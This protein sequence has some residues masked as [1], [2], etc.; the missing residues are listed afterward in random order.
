MAEYYLQSPVEVLEYQVYWD[1]VI[2]DGVTIQTSVWVAPTPLVVSSESIDAMFTV[3]K[4]E[5]G[6][7]GKRYQVTNTITRSN[8]EI[9]SSSLFIYFEVK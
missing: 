5:G 8:G 7:A 1:N 3:C 4:I 6:L 2:T 9:L